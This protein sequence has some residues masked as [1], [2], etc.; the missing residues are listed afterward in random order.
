MSF[1]NAHV[2]IVGESADAIV[3][4]DGESIHSLLILIMAH[5]SAH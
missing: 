2:D 5:L 4:T 3:C 1:S